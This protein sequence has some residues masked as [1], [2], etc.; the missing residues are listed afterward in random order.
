MS[1]ECYMIYL[2][3]M[4]MK[5]F[6]SAFGAAQV[7]WKSRMWLLSRRLVT[8][9]LWYGKRY[10]NPSDILC[11]FTKN[12]G[13]THYLKTCHVYYM[14]FWFCDRGKWRL[15]ILKKKKIG[16]WSV[17]TWQWQLPLNYTIFLFVLIINVDRYYDEVFS[18]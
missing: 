18:W 5:V 1:W 10:H 12:V 2:F 9:G 8:P 14:W 6:C 17:F 13:F 3:W 7:S 16:Q 15:N 11:T 4:D